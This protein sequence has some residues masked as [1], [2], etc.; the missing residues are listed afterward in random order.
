MF[1]TKINV[2]KL[3]SSDAML[4]TT[5][6]NVIII[7]VKYFISPFLITMFASLNIV[8]KIKSDNKLILLTDLLLME[9]C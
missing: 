2:N 1:S 3:N 7:C 4:L 6:T 5:K 8:S 9:N